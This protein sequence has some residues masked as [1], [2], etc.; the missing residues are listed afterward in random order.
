MRNKNIF[1]GIFMLVVLAGCTS[2]SNGGSNLP[3]WVSNAYDSDYS[4]S[5]YL[6]AV[7]SGESKQ[8]AEKNAKNSLSQ[9]FNTSVKSTMQEFTFDDGTSSESIFSSFDTLNSDLENMLGIE[10][11]DVYQ[12]M[13]KEYWVRVCLDKNKAKNNIS[14]SVEAKLTEVYSL[15]S[16]SIT[17]V[18]PFEKY[19]LLRQAKSLALK[20]QPSIDQLS[21]L[22]GYTVTS[23]LTEIINSL[24]K[25]KSNLV[26]SLDLTKVS[27]EK[28]DVISSG[29]KKYL[30]SQGFTITE[31]AKA[32][33]FVTYEEIISTKDDFYYCNN[34]FT[35]TL[36]SNG[37]TIDS[38]TSAVRGIGINEK[39][40]STKAVVKTLKSM[41]NEFLVK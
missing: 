15:I 37:I 10:V 7:G 28:K 34:D 1:L 4:S 27:E 23:P 36:E 32:T 29:L 3:S 39:A 17:K 21:V 25:I 24:T 12:D 14:A 13:E 9:I 26:I 33:L 30:E 16:Q 8:Q 18:N 6:C 35:A 2:I 11:A 31:G 38:F 40:A 5:R 20:I 22:N 41:E 19:R